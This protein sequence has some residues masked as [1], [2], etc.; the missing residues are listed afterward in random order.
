[1]TSAS[2]LAG[3]AQALSPVAAASVEVREAVAPNYPSNACTALFDGRVTVEVT[4]LPGGGLGDTHAE[5]SPLLQA[6]AVPA[7]LG[8]RF[9]PPSERTKVRL[10]FVFKV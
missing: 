9:V 6:A 3:Q 2:C 7:A 1:M 10:T 5:G 8:W 4:V